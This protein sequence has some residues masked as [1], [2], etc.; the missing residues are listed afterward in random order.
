[1]ALG[2]VLSRMKHWDGHW[3]DSLALCWI[4]LVAALVTLAVMPT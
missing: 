1:M 2:V 4:A 3:A